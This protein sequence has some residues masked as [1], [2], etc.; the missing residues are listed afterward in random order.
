MNLTASLK[1]GVARMGALMGFGNGARAY[2]AGRW[3]TRETIGWNSS[4]STSNDEILTTR[5]QVV[6]R[7]RDL[8]RNNP[9]I[10]G[11]ID[12]LSE[13]VVG[14]RLRPE[15][16][17][18]FS[19]LGKSADWADDWAENV[20]GKWRSYAA[21]PRSD[22]DGK[23]RLPHMFR[24][25]YRHWIIDGEACAVVYSLPGR[26]KYR[27]AFKLI[28]PDRLSNPAGMAD[29][30]KLPNGNTIIGGV[31]ISPIGEAVAYHVRKRHPASSAPSD[32]QFT[33][34]RIPRYGPTGRPMFIHAFR[35]DRAD[36]RRGVSRL[37][38]AILTA[39]MSDRYDKATLEKELLR[40]VNSM[41][42]KSKYPSAD[43]RD[44]LAPPD[45]GVETNWADS[46]MDWR[47]KS[48][49]RVDGVDVK[50]LFPEEEVDMPNPGGDGGAHESISARWD[51]KAAGA[52][53]LSYPHYSQNWADIN[54]S[55]GRLMRN[56]M[57]RSFMEDRDLFTQD[58]CTAFTTAWLEEAV[59]IGDVKLP[60]RAASFYDLKP[61]LCQVEWMG[62]GPGYGDPK[63]EAEA[64]DI[65]LGQYTATH[66]SICADKGV[67]PRDML[68]RAARERKLFEAAGL[69]DPI[70]LR[71]QAGP[72]RP[73]E[74]G[75]AGDEVR[76]GDG[77]FAPTGGKKP[78]PDDGGDA[79]GAE[80]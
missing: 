66:S 78:Q 43:V 44:A 7:A 75:D 71:K 30:M 62:P 55:S 4:I 61:A 76:S 3:D 57:W 12:R 47:G 16:Q 77:K 42:I 8:C 51:R 54:Y 29:E 40:A 26:G 34:I 45:S 49:L 69:I 20:E 60:G 67:D 9:A 64:N 18:D 63:K 73:A 13:S 19:A 46:W 22:V 23:S 5:D 48:A 37:V 58:F 2:D 21:S 65:E 56:E 24:A 14:P 11:A 35:Y 27:T 25:A 39:K 38:S 1:S 72:G 33:W 32:E 70:F 31:E 74:G 79:A 80:E 6:A 53:G 36:Q 10:S 68:R 15:W 17:P 28:D 50:V 52:I 59:A 41:F